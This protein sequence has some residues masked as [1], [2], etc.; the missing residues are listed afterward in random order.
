MTD[1]KQESHYTENVQDHLKQVESLLHK[2]ALL[3]EVVHRQE[4]PRDDRHTLLDTLVHKQHIAELKRLLDNLHPA[5]IA[6]I[7]EALPIE[8]RLLVWSLVKADRMDS[9]EIP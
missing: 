9:M 5:D 7:L 4:L 1:F 6:Y 3:E 2:H 8:Q